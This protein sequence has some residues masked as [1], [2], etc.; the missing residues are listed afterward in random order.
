MLGRIHTMQ[1]KFIRLSF[2]AIT[3]SLTGCQSGVS[4]VGVSRNSE[5]GQAIASLDDAERQYQK[6]VEVYKQAMMDYEKAHGDSCGHIMFSS[7]VGPMEKPERRV[8]I[9]KLQGSSRRCGYQ[10]YK[11]R[12]TYEDDA[13]RIVKTVEIL[14]RMAQ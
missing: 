9:N 13:C 6:N 8:Q 4:N 3:L 2:L 10:N 7:I 1:R 5:T 11:A 12:I 14:E